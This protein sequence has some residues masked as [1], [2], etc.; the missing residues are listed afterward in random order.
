MKKQFYS[1]AAL[2]LICAVSAVNANN[3]WGQTFL[4]GRA[5]F[6]NGLP[7]QVSI[8]ETFQHDNKVR[9][10]KNGCLQVAAFYAANTN[11]DLAATYYMPSNYSTWY[12][13]DIVQ[14]TD[15]IAPQT[16]KSVM[17]FV[18]T[19]IGLMAGAAGTPAFNTKTALGAPITDG[20]A[21]AGAKIAGTLTTGDIRFLGDSTANGV[22]ATVNNAVTWPTI[23]YVMVGAAVD[24][25]GPSLDTP[26]VDFPAVPGTNANSTTFGQFADGIYITTDGTA[27]QAGNNLLNDVSDDT[28]VIRAWNFGITNAAIWNPT[29][30]FTNPVFQSTIA[31]TLKLTNGGAAISYR[32]QFG[33]DDTTG[34]FIKGSTAVQRV[35]SEWLWNE[36]VLV[37]SGAPADLPVTPLSSPWHNSGFPE[38]ASAPLN[39]TQAFAQ[40]AWNFGKV[41]GAQSITR[42]ADIELL[43]GYEFINEKTHHTNAYLGL[44]IPTGNK[45]KGIYL[46]EPVVGNGGH[47]GVMYG[48]LL[49]IQMSHDDDFIVTTRLDGNFRYLFQNTQTRA[50]D[51][52]DSPWS[53]YMMVWPNYAALQAATTATNTNRS[54]TPGINVFTQQVKVTPGSQ[55]LI[56]SAIM[57]ES[58]HFKGELGCNM[59]ARQSEKISLA[60]TW[61]AGTVAIAAAE[62]EGINNAIDASIN[63]RRT[64]FNNSP[65]TQIAPGGATF[66]NG[67]TLAGN[68]II[69][70]AE[71]SS[72]SVQATDLNLDSAASQT[73]LSWT[74]YLVLGYGWGQDGTP[75]FFS[76][77]GSYEFT[78]ENRF[79]NQWQVWGKLGLS[80]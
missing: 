14:G 67:T 50:L 29:A 19:N 48:G 24:L 53:R 59:M 56:N 10:D 26:G 79:I 75:G 70:Q 45:A 1:I 7:I 58:E 57:L 52:K 36:N 28:S 34:F 64:I 73:A 11:R 39:L 2:A 66:T 41:N 5:P 9:H 51:L 80:F 46:A 27:A 4:R 44:V 12:V 54:Y 3:V 6:E 72:Y 74:P 16:G 31:P 40:T 77:G 63:P 20:V 43:V 62:P 35:R 22:A 65:L 33:H 76:L 18:A 30:G 38:G 8:T 55:L 49:E 17:N 60:N 37:A 47:F 71:Y 61:A 21:I 32:Q 42:L 25:T 78:L 23:G 68:T 15:G 13:N 69:T